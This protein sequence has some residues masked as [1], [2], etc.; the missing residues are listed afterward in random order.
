M[1]RYE[2]MTT[3]DHHGRTHTYKD[4]AG[5]PLPTPDVDGFGIARSHTIIRVRPAST[6]TFKELIHPDQL[7]ALA[8]F[9]NALPTSRKGR[10]RGRR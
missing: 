1:I 5:G 2:Y 9:T 6:W 8:R 7:I 3:R 4:I 10:T